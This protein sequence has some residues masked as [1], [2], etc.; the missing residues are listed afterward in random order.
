M[1][2][3]ITIEIYALVINVNALNRRTSVDS[4][5]VNIRGRGVE[6]DERRENLLFIIILEVWKRGGENRKV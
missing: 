4:C 3:A 5:A 2:R 6:R 1:T